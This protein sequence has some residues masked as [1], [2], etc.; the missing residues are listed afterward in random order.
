MPIRAR[1][2][3]HTRSGGRHCQNWADDQKDIID[4]LNRIPPT[5]GG[6]GGGL[7]PRIVPGICSDELYAAISAFEDKYFPGQRNGFIDPGGPVYQKLAI[8]LSPASAPAPAAPPPAAAPAAPATGKI[9]RLL[10]AGEKGLLFPIFGDTINYNEQI[11][12]RNDGEVGGPDNSFTPGYFPNMA[13]N[14]WS[15][16]Y[17]GESP[18]RTAVFV[19]EMVH[20]WQSG[21][22]SHNV[23]RG[24]YLW[25]KYDHITGDYDNSYE[26]D[27]DSSTS[28]SDFNMEQQA[29][30]IEDY[31]RVSKSLAPD[32]NVGT[33]KSVADYLPYVSQLKVAGPFQSPGRPGESADDA[34]ARISRTA[35]GRNAP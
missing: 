2:G 19:H 17:S 18:G 15:W 12:A 14:L 5:S 29:Q 20:T 33:R 32:K 6:T 35:H 26:Y 22:G 3:R 23:L 13:P 28:L 11:V 10:T 21:H 9:P 24:L 25:I 34:R 7:H 4:L 16:D 27:L 31:Y 8:L 30:I 1:V